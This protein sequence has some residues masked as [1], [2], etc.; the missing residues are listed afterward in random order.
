MKRTLWVEHVISFLDGFGVCI[1]F[2]NFRE[3]GF[4]VFPAI[5]LVITLI[6]FIAYLAWLDYVHKRT[7][8]STKSDNEKEKN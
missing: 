1:W 7:D 4:D 3:S 8:A 6:F 2:M 5:M